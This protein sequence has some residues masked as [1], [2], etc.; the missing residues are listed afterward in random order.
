MIPGHGTAADQRARQG[1][2]WSNEETNDL[3]DTLGKVH[4][5]KACRST[6]RGPLLGSQLI[7]VANNLQSQ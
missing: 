5:E 7:T 2:D 6:F 1:V 4:K 3:N